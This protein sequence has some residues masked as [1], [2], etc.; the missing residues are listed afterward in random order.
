[1]KVQT[2]ED[3]ALDIGEENMYEVALNRDETVESMQVISDGEMTG[4]RFPMATDHAQGASRN[5]MHP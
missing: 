5:Q 4:G 3:D 2:T 1:M